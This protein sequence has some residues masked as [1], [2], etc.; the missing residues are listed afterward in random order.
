MRRRCRSC[1]F[2]VSSQK[3]LNHWYAIEGMNTAEMT[4]WAIRLLEITLRSSFR[5]I[6][7]G[8]T[9]QWA[10]IRMAIHMASRFDTPVARVASKHT[11]LHGHCRGEGSG[12][13]SHSRDYRT[14]A[15]FSQSPGCT[16]LA[17]ES[18]KSWSGV[19]GADFQKVGVF[20]QPSQQ[21]RFGYSSRLINRRRQGYWRVTQANPAP[22]VFFPI[23]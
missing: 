21:D 7:P 11:T 8:L 22:C 23:T 3:Y 17:R 9:S 5:P 1:G 2:S 10:F 12:S 18:C 6:I 13:R 16:E 19:G 15:G 14:L 20:R 4:K